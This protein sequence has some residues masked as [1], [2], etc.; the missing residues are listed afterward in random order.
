MNKRFLLVLVLCVAGLGLIFWFN[1][2]SSNSPSGNAQLSSHI[3]GKGNKKVALVEYGDFQCPACAQYYPVIKQIKEKYKNDIT[4][5]FVNFPLPSHQKTF[6]A[7]RAAEAASL[8]G[9]F[10]Q[11]HDLLYENQNSWVESAD[12][13]PLFESFA[14]SLGLDIAKFKQDFES[15]AV[16]DVIN[17][18]KQAGLKLKV[19][20]TPTFFLEGK[21]LDPSPTSLD[22]FSKLIKQAIADKT[23]N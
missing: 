11:M 23:E 6:A 22:S 13:Y 21:L 12:S 2:D 17:A 10:W 8:Q 9:K 3:F 15:P 19:D 5:Q 16:N 7:H 18:D 1:K 4:F 14:Q 20:S